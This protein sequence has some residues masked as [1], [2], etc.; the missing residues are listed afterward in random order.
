MG[1][2][3]ISCL[4]WHL[5]SSAVSSLF[6]GVQP[7]RRCRSYHLLPL[8]C[9]CIA[10]HVLS[11]VSDF[12]EGHTCPARAVHMKGC[13]VLGQQCS[14]HDV[15]VTLSRGCIASSGRDQAA[16]AA[17]VSNTSYMV[18]AG[19]TPAGRFNERLV[20][21]LASNTACLLMDDELN[22]LP[23]SSHVKHIEPIQ[24]HPDGTPA[25]PN[26]EAQSAA[27]LKDL[28]SSLE[29]TQVSCHSACKASKG[30]CLA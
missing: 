23:T 30:L 12:F 8:R 20:L 5:P 26:S 19:P 13:G 14:Q 11:D 25:V 9:T 22:I 28:A 21:S 27:E 15:S 1:M 16:G 6:G 10:V 4:V 24:L 29:D 3:W 2:Q 18:I 7:A 17:L